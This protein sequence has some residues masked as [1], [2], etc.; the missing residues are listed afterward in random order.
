MELQP[1]DHRGGT[2]LLLA[3]WVFSQMPPQRCS[4]YPLRLPELCAAQ[5]SPTE[6]RG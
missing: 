1:A 5:R 3:V 2:H 4:G 6:W